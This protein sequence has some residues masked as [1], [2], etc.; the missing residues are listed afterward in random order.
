MPYIGQQPAP[1]P[2]TASDVTDGIITSAK[3]AD[4]TITSG[5]IASGVITSDMVKIAQTNVTSAVSSVDFIDGTGGVVIDSTYRIYKIFA[6][7]KPSTNGEALGFRLINSGT[8][9]RTSG[10]L[11]EAHRSYYTGGTSRAN[12]TSILLRVIGGAQNASDQRSNHE[13]TFYNMSDSSL[14]TT[15]NLIYAAIDGSGNTENQVN[16]GTGGGVYTTA[17]AHNGIRILADN[18]NIE[19][20][21]FTLYGIKG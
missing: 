1:V 7:F 2:L 17:E 15:A 21:E 10:Y 13:A 18:G 9:V 11:A 12:S 5:D 3:I 14:N 16:Q 6:T 20:G 8:N 4:G 19:S